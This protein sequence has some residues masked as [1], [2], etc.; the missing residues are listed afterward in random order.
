MPLSAQTRNRRPPKPAP[1]LWSNMP[2]AIRYVLPLVLVV[3]IGAWAFSSWAARYTYIRVV[4]AAGTEVQSGVVEFFVFDESGAA[5]SPSAKL[6]EL[7]FE[8]DG[9]LAV[10]PE[11]VPG[12]ALA[13]IR[14]DGFGTGFC[15]LRRGAQTEPCALGRPGRAEGVVRGP[16]GRGVAEAFVQAFGGGAHGVL[17]AEAVTGSAGE[18]VLSGFSDTVPS[19]HVRAR[20]ESFAVGSL[21]LWIEGEQKRVIELLRTAPVPGSVVLPDGVTGDLRVQGYLVPGVEAPV[22]ADGRFAIDHLPPPPTRTSLIVRGL[23]EGY[24]HRKVVVEPGSWEA[25]IV[26]EPAAVVE[27]RVIDYQTGEPVPRA[28]VRHEHGPSGVEVAACDEGGNFRIGRLP[29]G[30]VVLQ[31]IVATQELD[32]SGRPR[33]A[34]RGGQRELTLEPRDHRKN[35]AISIRK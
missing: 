32:D 21:E 20:K 2:V 26:V 17:L 18:F 15:Y 16:D 25:E 11:L 33:K 30:A 9:L 22:G 10:G 12:E 5:R 35:I 6:G 14:A 24:T 1:G 29:A 34:W 8:G 3:G 31:A 27:G 19:L 13:R 4:D 23:P 7:V 28:A